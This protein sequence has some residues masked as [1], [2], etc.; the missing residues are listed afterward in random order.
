M[1]VVSQAT[2]YRCKH[3]CLP[4]V[5]LLLVLEN[6]SPNDLLLC[7]KVDEIQNIFKNEKYRNFG[8]NVFN[9]CYEEGFKGFKL[10]LNKFISSFGKFTT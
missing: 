5:L 1:T 9:F 3:F 2:M 7:G 8:I 4:D 10:T 6:L